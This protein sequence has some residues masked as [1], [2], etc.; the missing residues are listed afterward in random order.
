MN[1]L[2]LFDW[3]INPRVGGVQRVTDVLARE[4]LSR[5]HRVFFLCTQEDG[6]N[7]ECDFS[8]PQFKLD[9]TNDNLGKEYKTILEEN[10]IEVII[11][12]EARTNTLL[13]LSLTPSYIKRITCFHTLPFLAIGR[14]RHLLKYR[15]RNTVKS[16]LYWLFCSIYPKYYSYSS[17]KLEKQRILESYSLSDK[18]CFESSRYFSRVKAV[19][20]SLDESRFI[21]ISNPCPFKRRSIKLCKEKIIMWAGRHDNTSKNFEKFVDFWKVFSS[22]NLDWKA[23]VVGDGPD[24]LSNIKYANK[25][26]VERIV[27]TGNVPEI[28]PYYFKATFFCMTSVAEGFPM[29]L[30]EAMNYQCIPVA[31]DTF[32]S[33]HDIIEDDVNG[34]I[35]NPY[36]VNEMSNR[37]SNLIINP[38]AIYS[39]QKNAAQK[40]ANFTVTAAI[41]KWESIL[42]SI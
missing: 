37:I 21:S 36:N 10:K 28:E 1:I 40:V 14:E 23:V 22:I 42:N 25:K 11:N 2:F 19:L 12:Q 29:V 5:G 31:F 34:I 3:P 4:F 30:L 8:C 27:F 38:S 9:C 32:E 13:L 20:P 26:N 24:W 35:V 15:D 16:F 7:Y 17:T 18:L 33:L 41:D 39:M 6:T